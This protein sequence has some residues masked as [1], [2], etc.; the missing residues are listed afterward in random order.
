MG[1]LLNC[2]IG[3]K[4]NVAVTVDNLGVVPS[5][6]NPKIL[7][8]TGSQTHALKAHKELI[9]LSFVMNVDLRPGM[10]IQID[11]RPGVLAI[12]NVERTLAPSPRS[13]AC[14]TARSTRKYRCPNQN[15]AR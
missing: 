5:H 8:L 13:A 2:R 15:S 7:T 9:I 4:V 14:W 6:D 3:H 10:R 12:K 11:G 1:K